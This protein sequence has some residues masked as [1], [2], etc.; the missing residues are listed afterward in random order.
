MHAEGGSPLAA[1]HGSWL[2]FLYRHG[3]PTWVDE[4][5][6]DCWL[7]ILVLAVVTYAGTRRLTLLPKP[8]QNFLELVVEQLEAFTT[9]IMGPE[10][11]VFV[12]FVGT[13]F[14]YILVMNLLGLIPGFLSPTASLNTTVALALCVFAATHY[15]GIRK[16]GAWGYLKHLWGEPKALGPLMFV[17]H[18]MEECVARPVSLAVRLFGNIF[19]KETVLAQLGGVVVLFLAAGFSYLFGIGLFSFGVQVFVICLALLLGFVQALIFAT[20]ASV[21]IAGAME[22]H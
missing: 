21:Y 7:L 4:P 14:L 12:P 10:G 13:L 1:E 6:L 8:A 19:G 9:R 17:I 20:L 5:V 2:H 16:R 15:H 3:V 11:K 18:L 22:E